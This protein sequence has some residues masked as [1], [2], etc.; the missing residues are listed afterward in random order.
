MVKGGFVPAAGEAVLAPGVSRELSCISCLLLAGSREH[1]FLGRSSQ[2]SRTVPKKHLVLQS[3]F[4]PLANS[5]ARP[6]MFA[7]FSGISAKQRQLSLEER[8]NKFT[9]Q[10][11]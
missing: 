8:F 5:C 11:H 1:E 3:V 9:F 2:T 7:E 10:C 6:R 4:P